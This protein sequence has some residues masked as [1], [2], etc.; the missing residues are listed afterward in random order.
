MGTI[1]DLFKQIRDIKGIFHTRMDMIKDR[2]CKD[3][4]EGEEIKKRWPEY[5]EELYKKVLNDPGNH[6][7]VVTQNQTSWSV[8]SSG[9]WET[10]LWTKLMEVM[11]F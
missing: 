4:T 3:L 11:E 5:T 2:N 7:S 6:D 10:L 1:Q 8:E 9:P